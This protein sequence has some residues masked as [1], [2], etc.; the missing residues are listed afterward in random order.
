MKAAFVTIFMF[1]SFSLQANAHGMNKAGPHGGFIRMPGMYH[2]ELVP[3][4]LELKVYFLDMN[5][6]PMP[7]NDASLE[8]ILVG[9]KPQ[10][11]QCLKE[12]HFFRCD[13]NEQSYKKYKEVSVESSINGSEDVKS[14]YKVPLKFM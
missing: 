11:A 9:K 10:K 13:T 4:G 2:I 1:S 12:I 6:K 5:F 14:V 7:I 3:S 8:L